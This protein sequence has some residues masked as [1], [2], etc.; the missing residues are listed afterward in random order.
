MAVLSDRQQLAK[1]LATEIDKMDGAWV[2]SPLPLDEHARLRVQIKDIDR[3]R[4]VQVLRDWGW[5]PMFVSV[6]PR[7]CS[8]GLIGA[9]IYE[10]DLPRDRQ[11]IPQDEQR[12]IPR[13][14]LAAPRAKTEADA[15]ANAWYGVKK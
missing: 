13:D 5:A 14:T 12:A 2:T 15:I 11:L 1:Q 4:I 6:L 10:I 8:T 9:S 7:I 3:N